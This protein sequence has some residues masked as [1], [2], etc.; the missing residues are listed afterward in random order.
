MT[1]QQGARVVVRAHLSESALAEYLASEGI[2]RE[3]IITINEPTSGS[4]TLIFEG[5]VEQHAA[6]RNEM[7]QRFEHW[8][9]AGDAFSGT[10]P[11][12]RSA[13]DRSGRHH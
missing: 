7:T 11:S 1:D 4:Y 3:Q 2:T 6:Y 13:G 8:K 12:C 5:T 10:L 9:R